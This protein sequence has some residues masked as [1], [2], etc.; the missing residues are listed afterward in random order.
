MKIAEVENIKNK[1]IYNVYYEGEKVYA[2]IKYEKILMLENK[3]FKTVQDAKKELE[4]DWKEGRREILK[5]RI[6]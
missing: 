5:I 2:E 1:E 4:K 6:F 3:L